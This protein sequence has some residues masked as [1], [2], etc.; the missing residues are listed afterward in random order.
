MNL[1]YAFFTATIAMILSVNTATSN[2]IQHENYTK[3]DFRDS[4]TYVLLERFKAD[5]SLPTV[6][7]AI[8]A[9]SVVYSG[10]ADLNT[11]PRKYTK[12]D[13]RK[14]ADYTFV[15]NF[16][17][18]DSLHHVEKSAP[19]EPK[20]TWSNYIETKASECL[21][22]AYKSTKSAFES[23]MNWGSKMSTMLSGYIS[24]TSWF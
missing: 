3:S 2:L 18:D 17:A 15:E 21:I 8:K 22:Y 23:V 24:A 19:Q 4:A 13:F 10:D 7:P 11:A 6:V 14:A 20:R 12:A 1:N 5:D 16:K 9:A